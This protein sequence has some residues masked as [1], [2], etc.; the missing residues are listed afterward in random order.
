M[1]QETRSSQGSLRLE[2]ARRAI[3]GRPSDLVIVVIGHRQGHAPHGLPSGGHAAKAHAIR[4]GANWSR[5]PGVIAAGGQLK[6]NVQRIH[7]GAI[8]GPG[9]LRNLHSTET[10]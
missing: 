1:W 8:G 2:K 4:A 9:S 3:D 7:T 5:R 6:L 10:L